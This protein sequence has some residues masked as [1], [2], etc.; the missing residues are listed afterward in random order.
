MEAVMP[1]VTGHM[2]FIVWVS[3]CIIA[4]KANNNK[5]IQRGCKTLAI[6]AVTCTDREVALF[7]KSAES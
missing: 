7:E 4:Q 6:G 5:K 2:E 3:R 1:K